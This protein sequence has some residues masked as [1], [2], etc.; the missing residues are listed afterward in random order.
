[1][2]NTYCPMSENHYSTF[3]QFSVCWQHK[4]QSS[5]YYFLTGVHPESFQLE[6]VGYTGKTHRFWKKMAHSSITDLYGIN[7]VSMTNLLNFLY[8]NLFICK[9]R[10]V[11]MVS[12]SWFI[13]MIKWVHMCQ[14]FRR[15]DACSKHLC[16]HFY[17]TSYSI[18]P[19][20]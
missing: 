5:L 17:Y 14:A 15:A 6:V 16:N 12:P 2:Y 4:D 20:T 9:I 19:L 7:Y 10:M 11:I 18:H 8:L 13:A 3:L 1:M